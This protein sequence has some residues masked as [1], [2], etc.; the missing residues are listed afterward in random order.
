MSMSA[1]NRD[2][3][4]GIDVCKTCGDPLVI[5]PS[6]ANP[7][8]KVPTCEECGYAYESEEAEDEDREPTKPIE[9]EILR[10]S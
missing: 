3:E 10:S 7:E 8:I 6:L 2:Y 5:L 1:P 4:P 9:D